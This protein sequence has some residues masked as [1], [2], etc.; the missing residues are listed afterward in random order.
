MGVHEVRGKQHRRTLWCF[1]H[2]LSVKKPPLATFIVIIERKGARHCPWP[3]FKRV[4]VL[5]VK[6][7]LFVSKKFVTGVLFNVA[8]GEFF[9]VSTNYIG[10]RRKHMLIELLANLWVFLDDVRV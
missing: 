5:D 2:H 7:A 10:G 9:I 3:S 6:L 1:N 4:G 8:Q